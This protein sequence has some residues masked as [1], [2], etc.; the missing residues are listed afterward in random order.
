MVMRCDVLAEALD[1]SSGS[2]D[3]RPRLLMSP[4]GEPLTQNRV[5]EL[6]A[7]PGAIIVW[8][9]ESPE[10]NQQ[11]KDKIDGKADK[12]TLSQTVTIMDESI[13][14]ELLDEGHIYFL[15]TQKL[16]KSSNLTKHSD[17]RQYTIWETL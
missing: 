15:N 5:R 3:P 9:S 6:A 13:D 16:G 2:D 17:N 4:R 8:L 7:G 11:S 10:L 14:Q 1:A 12:I